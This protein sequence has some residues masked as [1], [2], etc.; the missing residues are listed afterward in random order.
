MGE[1]ED[2]KLDTI[3]EDLDDDEEYGDDGGEE[4]HTIYECHYEPEYRYDEWSQD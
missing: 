1:I 2:N 3:D 4:N